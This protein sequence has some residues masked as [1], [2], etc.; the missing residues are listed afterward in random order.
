MKKIVTAA[1]LLFLSVN[2]FP[3]IPWQ[4]PLYQ[5]ENV[6]IFQS[7]GRT[8]LRQEPYDQTEEASSW[9]GSGITA[10]DL[11]DQLFQNG[12]DLECRDTKLTSRYVMSR[13]DKL[14]VPVLPGENAVLTEVAW[15]SAMEY[16]YENADGLNS[17]VTVCGDRWCRTCYYQEK[18]CA[19]AVSE[20]ATEDYLDLGGVIAWL[21]NEDTGE[22]MLSG[23]KNGTRFHANLYVGQGNL[24]KERL[25]EFEFKV[26]YPMHTLLLP[27]RLAEAGRIACAAAF[28]TGLVLLALEFA[29]P[30]KKQIIPDE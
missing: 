28:L 1:I 23:E 18:N 5:G 3:L 24:T 7:P 8:E 14:Y 11:L 12:D 2:I 4:V 25:S 15:D 16:I 19:E 29:R 26:Y 22:V 20:G 30:R 27:Y 10:D 6:T 21:R 13:L 9:D 17:E